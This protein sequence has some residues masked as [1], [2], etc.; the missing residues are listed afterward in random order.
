MDFIDESY[1]SIEE[2]MSF[3]MESAESN[4]LLRAEIIEPIMKVLDTKKGSDE[5]LKF[6]T[7]FIESNADMLAREFPTKRVSFPKKYV[8][9]ILSVFGFNMNDFKATVK[10]L[11][12]DI[13]GSDFKTIMATP[14]NIIHAVVLFY[15]DMTLNRYVR[16]SARQQLALTVY[17]VMFNKFYHALPD[18]KVMAYTYMQLNRNWSIVKAEDMM[19][20]ISDIVDSAYAF[21]KTRLTINTTMQ[22][23]VM[24]LNRVRTQ[25]RQAMHQLANVYFKNQTEGNRINEDSETGDTEYI[26]T[27]DT[28]QTRNKLM[29]L[30]KRG[31]S[32]YNTE[33]N[34][35]AGVARLKNV[36]AKALYDLAQQ[37]SHH[38]ISELIDMIF[39]VFIVK[40]GHTIKD[41][42]SST[43]IGEIT[44]LPTKVDR[45]IPGKPIIAPY[46]KKYKVKK[47]LIVAYI[48][49]IAT[50][51]MM[52]INDVTK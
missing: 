27:D 45:C 25:M 32:L 40:E 20:W 4:R 51:I 28:S 12:E 34:L 31:D 16:D 6:G 2:A 22:T 46:V 3:I 14:T 5:Y 35:Y 47:E 42:N 21:Y 23:I 43:Y 15:S 41:I 33:S 44:N 11:C 10:T 29:Q 37:V 13:N 38:D 19:T 30:L 48:C 8:D 52:R 9:N 1:F 18:E 24:F 26:I 36:S 39:Y 17:H 50:W 7:E 49:L